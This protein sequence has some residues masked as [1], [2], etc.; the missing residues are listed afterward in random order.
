MYTSVKI[1][2]VLKSADQIDFSAFYL[3]TKTSTIRR[4]SQL[5]NL[6]SSNVGKMYLSFFLHCWK[7]YKKANTN[8]MPNAHKRHWRGKPQSIKQKVVFLLYAIY[9]Q[10]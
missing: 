9:T 8:K 4:V 10:E 7:Y 2:I 3:T 6:N 5:S 1:V